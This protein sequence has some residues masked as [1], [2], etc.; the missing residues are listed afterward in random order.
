MLRDLLTE[1]ERGA[2]KL[3]SAMFQASG[4]G[5]LSADGDQA[6]TQANSEAKLNQLLKSALKDVKTKN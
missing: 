6:E 1:L 4:D 3:S 2:M 5:E